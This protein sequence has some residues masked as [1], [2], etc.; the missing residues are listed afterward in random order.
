MYQLQQFTEHV[1]ALQNL[2]FG[3]F[4]VL[5]ILNWSYISYNLK[6]K[7]V[8]TLLIIGTSL[9]QHFNFNLQNIQLM[10]VKRFDIFDIIRIELVNIRHVQFF[11]I[12]DLIVSTLSQ[13]FQF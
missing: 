8:H 2:S 6:K 3:T 12:L 9:F 13:A 4:Y 5:F 7:S 1:L 11:A 10:F